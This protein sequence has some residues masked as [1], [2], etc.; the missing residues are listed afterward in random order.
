MSPE[1]RAN[2]LFGRVLWCKPDDGPGIKRELARAIRAAENA[3]LERAAK[4]AS[5]CRSIITP[6]DGVSR[7][8]APTFPRFIAEQIRSLKSRAPKR[9]ADTRPERLYIDRVTPA[10][11]RKAGRA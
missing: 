9:K 7:V 1:Q 11:K 3:A 4:T 2:A 6:S 8:E 10:P 5:K